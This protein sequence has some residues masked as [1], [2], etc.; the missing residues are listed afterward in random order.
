MTLYRVFW[1]FPSA[2]ENLPGGALYIPQQG[3]GR[4]DNPAQYQLLYVSRE[5]HGAI[6]EAFGRFSAWSAP[7]LERPPSL[8]RNAIRALATYELDD[9]ARVCDF[10]DPAQLLALR[11]RPS[12]VI[13]RDYPQVRRRALGIFQSGSWVGVQWW[14]WY[15]ASWTNVALWDQAPVRIIDERPLTLTDPALHTAATAIGRVVR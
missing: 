10:D 2:A 12:Q 13:T 7:I 9:R 15:E 5:P 6:A 11:M 4:F 8:P 3:S 1:S 14:S